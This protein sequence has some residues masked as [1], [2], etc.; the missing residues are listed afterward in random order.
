MNDPFARF[1]IPGRVEFATGNGGLAK[2]IVTSNTSTAEIYLHGAHV[3]HFQQN[4]E[5]PLLFLSRKSHFAVGEPIRG[6]VPIC[7]P[8]FGP[9]DGDPAHGLARILPWDVAETSAASDGR[10]TVR[11]RLP[12][13]S[14]KP[15][16]SSLKTEF[17]VTVADTLTMELI[18]T[19][20]SADKTLEIENCL[21][22]YFHVGDISAG[23]HRRLAKRAIRRLRRRRQ[24]RAQ[25]GK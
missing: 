5:P 4:G 7:F 24:R 1:K 22:T 8:W 25:G 18:A 6:G 16:W 14:V 11:L 19:N 10:A 9:R 13:D 2:I 15:E 12:K 23:F 3:T 20:E 21:H 17:V